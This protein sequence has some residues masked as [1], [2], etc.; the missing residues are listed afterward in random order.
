MNA[1]RK[2]ET[3]RHFLDISEIP[4]VELRRVLDASTAMKKARAKGAPNDA[5]PLAGKT[6]AMI[7]DRP[8]T[9][10]RQPATWR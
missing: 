6:L 7:F 3:A 5:R 2:M 9:R 4:A 10:T 1:I 8:S